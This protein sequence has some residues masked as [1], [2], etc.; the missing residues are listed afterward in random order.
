M[1]ES[2]LKFT[3]QASPRFPADRGKKVNVSVNLYTKEKKWIDVTFG[4]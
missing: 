3:V 2:F 4:K 1:Y